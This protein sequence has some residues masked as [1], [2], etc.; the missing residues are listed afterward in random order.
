MAP[1]TFIAH[2]LSLEFAR[3]VVLVALFFVAFEIVPLVWNVK[4]TIRK[5][6][7]DLGKYQLLLGAYVQIA[8]LVILAVLIY[9]KVPF[10][11]IDIRE[12]PIIAQVI[13]TYLCIDFFIYIAHFLVHRYRIPL[14]SRAHGYHHSITT[15]LQWVNSRKE[16][17]IILALFASVFVLF[18]YVVFK[19]SPATSI[20]VIS[21]GL[22]LNAFSHFH[23]PFAIP[24]LDKF[25]LF[26]R[27]HHQHH[28]IRDSG[29]YGVTLT[30]FDTLFGTRNYLPPHRR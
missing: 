24:Y 25:F 20:I 29:P 3:L 5:N 15:D 19:V 16:H 26:P 9:L 18:L 13:I 17:P 11:N 14:L 27:E 8:G 1:I 10:G 30:I 23:I 21:L 6:L 12:L 7:P 4:S 22:F 28:T 2:A